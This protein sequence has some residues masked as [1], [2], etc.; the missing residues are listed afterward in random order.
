MIFQMVT[1]GWDPV[2]HPVKLWFI[3]EFRNV[4]PGALALYCLN[5]LAATLC[6][7]VCAHTRVC[8]RVCVRWGEGWRTQGDNETLKKAVLSIDTSQLKS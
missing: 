2:V 7:C 6:V 1:T 5:D 8:V 4:P 3:S